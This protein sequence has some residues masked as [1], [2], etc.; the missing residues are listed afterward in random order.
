MLQWVAPECPACVARTCSSGRTPA[1]QAA[2]AAASCWST[3]SAVAKAAFDAKWAGSRCSSGGRSSSAPACS[4]RDGHQMLQVPTS[5]AGARVVLLAAHTLA[6]A[7]SVCSSDGIGS[8][9][10][11]PGLSSK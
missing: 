11:H 7:G 3:S 1:L 2:P 8:T 5:C 10:L 9:G 6:S 4:Q